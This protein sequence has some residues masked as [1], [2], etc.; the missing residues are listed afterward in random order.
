ME[1][2]DSDILRELAALEAAQHRPLR[3]LAIDPQNVAARARML[4]LDEQ[5]AVL[6]EEIRGRAPASDADAAPEA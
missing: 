4:A 6:R 3:E 1:R 5:I 2:F